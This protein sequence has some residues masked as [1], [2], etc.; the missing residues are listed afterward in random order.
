LPHPKYAF[1]LNRYQISQRA[2]AFVAETANHYE[3]LGSAKGPPLFAVLDDPLGEATAN[4]GQ[5]LKLFGRRSVDI[6]SR[7]GWGFR[8]DLVRWRGPGW[9]LIRQ[10]TFALTLDAC[11]RKT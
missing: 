4:A 6:D 8:R 3:V 7:W 11:R 5:L 10:T 1:L 9:Q 2:K